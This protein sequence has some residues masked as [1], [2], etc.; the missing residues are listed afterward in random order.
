MEETLAL[1]KRRDADLTSK[2]REA[3]AEEQPLAAKALRFDGTFGNHYSKGTC[4]NLYCTK[5]H[6]TV[7]GQFLLLYEVLV[8]YEATPGAEADHMPRL[9]RGAQG[10]G[11]DRVG[12]QRAVCHVL[13][14]GF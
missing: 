11:V 14:V 12:L 6:R 13:C 3:I 2:L 8:T 10:K 4:Y 9:R 1:M 5:I 7:V